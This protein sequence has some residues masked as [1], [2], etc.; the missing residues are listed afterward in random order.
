MRSLIG[1]G[2]VVALAL[3]T[4]C[5]YVTQGDLEQKRACIDVDG[6]GAPQDVGVTCEEDLETAGLDT[7]EVDCD[8]SSADRAPHFEEI[9]YDGIDND[10]DGADL[11]DVDDDTKP[12]ISKAD[13]EALGGMAWPDGLPGGED[14]VDC[15][16]DDETVFPGSPFEAPYDGI[17]SDCLGDGDYDVDGDNYIPTLNPNTG[18]A[19]DPPYNGILEDGDCDDNN[20]DANPGAVAVDAPYD[21]VDINCDC[22]ND[23]DADGDGFMWDQLSNETAFTTYVARY[24]CTFPST[25]DW[26]DCDDDAAGVNPNATDEWYDGIDSDCLGDD[27]F[28]QDNDGFI[29]DGHSAVYTGSLAAGDCDD[30]DLNIFPSALELIGDVVDQDCDGGNDSSEFAFAEAEWESPRGP[31]VGWTGEHYVLAVGAQQW[32]DVST[33]TPQ[34][35]DW[36]GLLF[37]FPPDSDNSTEVEARQTWNGVGGQADPLGEVIDMVTDSADSRVY[38]AVS[39]RRSVTTGDNT[40]LALRGFQWSGSVYTALS[41]VLQSVASPDLANDVEIQIS[42]TGSVFAGSCGD[43]HLQYIHASW[44]TG[45]FSRKYVGATEAAGGQHCTLELDPSDD[46]GSLLHVQAPTDDPSPFLLRDSTAALFVDQDPLNAGTGTYA[47]YEFGV[48]NEDNGLV[49]IYDVV[50]GDT[51]VEGDTYTHTVFSNVV[52]YDIAADEAPNGD[53]FVVA[54]IEDQGTDGLKDLVMFHGTPGGT[55]VEVPLSVD[56]GRGTLEP[57]GA[58]I[59][60]D[61]SRVFLAAAMR[62]TDTGTPADDVGWMFLGYAP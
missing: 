48:V 53:L 58:S 3:A 12:G 44:S 42:D 45:S 23:F 41:P 19:H 39:M 10:C 14:D 61:D 36:P 38:L 16:D 40:Y 18:L 35:Q 54:V 26:G 50:T 4:G 22:A 46:A 57:H 8:E 20:A 47:G 27:D 59:H 43:P 51:T 55:L 9:P 17:D 33:G 11:L 15:D 62:D 21:G 6:D 7:Y 5:T 34:I 52:V 60:A 28:D 32:T 49:S 29:P 37:R 2:V 56:D 30:E 1:A 31:R 25:P 13:Y 24:G